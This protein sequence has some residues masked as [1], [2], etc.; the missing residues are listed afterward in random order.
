MAAA[1]NADVVAGEDAA[2]IAKRM[3]S[4]AVVAAD[5][6]L[7]MVFFFYKKCSRHYRINHY[8]TTY[9]EFTVKHAA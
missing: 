9:Y 6:T 7:A 1:S 3:T 8:L 4:A 5:V 2:S